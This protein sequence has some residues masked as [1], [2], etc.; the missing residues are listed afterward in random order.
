MLFFGG[1]GEGGGTVLWSREVVG[2][3][4]RKEIHTCVMSHGGDSGSKWWN[5]TERSLEMGRAD[6]GN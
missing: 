1:G 3:G 2:G 5:S 4:C 6:G